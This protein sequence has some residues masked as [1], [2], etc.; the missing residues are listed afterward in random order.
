MEFQVIIL[1]FALDK[2]FVVLIITVLVI[3]GIQEITVNIQY[4]LEFQVIIVQC[5]QV[6][7]IVLPQIIANALME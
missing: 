1:W 4:V 3:M 6:M 2:E 7:V 5:V